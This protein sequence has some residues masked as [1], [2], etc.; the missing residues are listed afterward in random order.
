M[1]RAVASFRAWWRRLLESSSAL[2]LLALFVPQVLGQFVK[3][4]ALSQG[5]VG[6]DASPFI[7]EVVDRAGPC[8]LF[9]D[10][11]FA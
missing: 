4:A 6:P 2:G 5:V 10:R 3:K 1:R 7:L 8:E 9:S 11:E